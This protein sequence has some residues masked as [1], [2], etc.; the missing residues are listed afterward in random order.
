MDILKSLLNKEQWQ[1]SEVEELCKK[2]NVMMGFVLERINDY[3]F[4]SSKTLDDI[5]PEVM[6]R[7]ILLRAI[8]LAQMVWKQS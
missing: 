3:S 4:D 1:Y 2:Y 6:H 8:Q 5:V 7:S